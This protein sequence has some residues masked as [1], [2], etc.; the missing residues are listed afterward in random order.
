MAC[1][2]APFSG[3]FGNGFQNEYALRNAWMRQYQ[4]ARW[5]YKTVIINDIK[6]EGARPPTCCSSS[7]SRALNCM[8]FLQQGQWRQMRFDA[9]DSIDEGRLIGLAEGSGQ[10]Q[11]RGS[12][13]FQA[14]TVQSS[15]GVLYALFG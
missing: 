7:T 5:P 9:R 4:F 3:Q 11:S 14:I 13:Q 10:Q 12:N 6:I 15:H 8:E 1:R 2:M